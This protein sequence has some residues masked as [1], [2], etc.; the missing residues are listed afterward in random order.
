MKNAFLVGEKVYLR[1]LDEADVPVFMEWINDFEVTRYLVAGVYPM[2]RWEEE[3]WVRSAR[4]ARDRVHLSIV[5]KDG[6]RLIGNTALFSID[7]VSR[8]AVFGILIGEKNEWGKG[9]GGEATALVVNYAFSRLNLN[10]VELTVLD[11]NDRAINCYRRIGFH[12]ESRLKGKR[13]AN[14]AFH[15][16]VVMATSRPSSEIEDERPGQASKAVP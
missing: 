3:E 7:Y 9:Y 11:F 1:P 5:L 2:T 10:R 4:G 14:G 6:D 8:F 16:E 12:E 13:W 15:D